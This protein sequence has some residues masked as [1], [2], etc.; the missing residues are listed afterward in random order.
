MYLSIVYVKTIIFFHFKKL[1]QKWKT[2]DFVW[3]KRKQ[4]TICS[5]WK[6]VGGAYDR[7][8]ILF[9]INVETGVHTYDV[10]EPGSKAFVRETAM[11]VQWRTNVPSKRKPVHVRM[12]TS[13]GYLIVSMPQNKKWSLSVST[14]KGKWTELQLKEKKVFLLEKVG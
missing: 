13:R 4:T 12:D 9:E 1:R 11:E 7:T 2:L 3:T 5:Y 6:F 10:L 14:M 8:E